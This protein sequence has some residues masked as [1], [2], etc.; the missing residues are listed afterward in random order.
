MSS[1]Y[2]EFVISNNIDWFKG[3]I[4]HN[5]RQKNLSDSEFRDDDFLNIVEVENPNAHKIDAQHDKHNV[6]SG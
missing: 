2:S 1:T 3:R 4:T 6:S 5:N